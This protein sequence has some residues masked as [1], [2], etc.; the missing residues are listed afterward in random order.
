MQ[1]FTQLLHE[2]QSLPAIHGN[3]DPREYFDQAHS[4]TY[5][6]IIRHF[7]KL[8]LTQKSKCKDYCSYIPPT[9]ISHSPFKALYLAELQEHRVFYEPDSVNSRLHVVNSVVLQYWLC[10]IAYSTWRL[11]SIQ[12]CMVRKRGFT[13]QQ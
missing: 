2:C 8:A 4:D 10:G 7:R 9:K 13:P 1:L 5:C 11:L 3:I 12:F 6:A